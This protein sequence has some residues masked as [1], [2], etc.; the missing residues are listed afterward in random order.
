MMVYG[1]VRLATMGHDVEGYGKACTAFAGAATT[2]VDFSLTES[3][4]S[5]ITGSVDKFS[6]PKVGIQILQDVGHWHV[7]EDMQEVAQ[8]VSS[9][10]QDISSFV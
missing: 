6:T 5:I 8:A 2:K 1:A 10:I 4:T 9:F 3:R 7:F